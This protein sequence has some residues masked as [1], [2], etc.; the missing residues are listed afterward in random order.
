M[1]FPFLLLV[2]MVLIWII[3]ILAGKTVKKIT[4]FF[5]RDTIFPTIFAYKFA[6]MF[7]YAIE[8][9]CLSIMLG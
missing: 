3:F 4:I 7:L 8:L 2:F 5:L 6:P 1:S 9:H